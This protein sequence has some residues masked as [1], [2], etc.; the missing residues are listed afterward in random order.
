MDC[1]LSEGAYIVIAVDHK[2]GAAQYGFHYF[3]CAHDPKFASKLSSI[4]VMVFWFAW[5]HS[6]PWMYYV[7]QLDSILHADD[8][9]PTSTL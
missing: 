5:Y 2:C 1:R 4:G 6:P 9:S 8:L 7:L 3:D